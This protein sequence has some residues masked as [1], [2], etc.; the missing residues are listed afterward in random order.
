MSGSVRTGARR[1]CRDFTTSGPWLLLGSCV[2]V[3]GPFLGLAWPRERGLQ[4][5]GQ[6]WGAPLRTEPRSCGPGPLLPDNRHRA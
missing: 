2:R 4:E 5:G 1:D 6:G 3:G